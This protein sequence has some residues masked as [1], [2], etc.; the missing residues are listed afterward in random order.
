MDFINFEIVKIS[1]Y[2][3]I[4]TN[5]EGQVPNRN[6]QRHYQCLYVSFQCVFWWT[7]WYWILSFFMTKGQGDSS[8]SLETHVNLVQRLN[9]QSDNCKTDKPANSKSNERTPPP[10]H[11][12]TSRFLWQPRQLNHF[13]FSIRIIWPRHQN[14]E[15]I[16]LK[17]GFLRG[18]LFKRVN[19][20]SDQ[21]LL[22]PP[23][24]DQYGLVNAYCNKLSSSHHPCCCC[25]HCNH[26]F[27]IIITSIVI[28]APLTAD[29]NMAKSMHTEIS[30]G[31]QA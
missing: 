21:I 16:P 28:T 24:C 19:S 8:N 14:S 25:N 30:L 13:I 3:C 22:P 7:L 2:H 27:L 31:R 10:Y 26:H 5:S 15:L 23:T 9:K 12:L 18:D 29:T 1:M 11:P 20:F 17:A 4:G 6:Q